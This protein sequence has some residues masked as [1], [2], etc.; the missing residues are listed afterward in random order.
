MIDK[1]VT[2]CSITQEVLMMATRL[3][4]GLVVSSSNEPI[5]YFHAFQ[6]LD[7]IDVRHNLC[8]TGHGIEFMVCDECIFI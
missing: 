3:S 5:A 6:I 7:K 4:Y 2:I 1:Q 8:H